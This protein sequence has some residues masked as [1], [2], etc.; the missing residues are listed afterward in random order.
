MTD[1]AATSTRVAP[2]EEER[3]TVAGAT[4]R[5]WSAPAAGSGS[6]WPPLPPWRSSSPTASVG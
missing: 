3:A 1:D 4:P 5:P 2:V 6:L